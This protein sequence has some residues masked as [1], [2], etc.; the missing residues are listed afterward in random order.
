MC[1]KLLMVAYGG[2]ETSKII[3]FITLIN[4]KQVCYVIFGTNWNF[5]KSE[6]FMSRFC[7]HSSVTVQSENQLWHFILRAE[8]R[9]GLYFFCKPPESLPSITRNHKKIRFKNFDSVGMIF[10]T[11]LLKNRYLCYLYTKPLSDRVENLKFGLTTISGNR[12]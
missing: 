7:S 6:L 2:S 3:I 5:S 11:Y 8:D 4:Y 9:Y 10:S 12:R 1:F